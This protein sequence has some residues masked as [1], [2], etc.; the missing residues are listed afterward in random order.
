MIMDFTT[1][2]LSRPGIVNRTFASFVDNLGGVEFDKCTLYI[3]IDPLPDGADRREV[4][5]VAERYFGTVVANMPSTPNFTAACNW[6]WSSA[7]SEVICHLEDDWELVR[8]VDM[9]EMVQHFETCD[10]LYQAVFRAYPYKYKKCVLSP[11]VM[12]RRFYGEIG[13]KLDT[14]LN[15]EIQLRGKQFGISM[16][17]PESKISQ[18]GKVTVPHRRIMVRDVGRRWAKKNGF[19]KPKKGIFTTYVTK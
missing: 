11:S 3:N 4:V 10:T 15:P 13:G 1:T 9:A 5:E 17:S 6:V 18:K 8:S 14:G 16:P 12:H 19:S 2:A 7:K